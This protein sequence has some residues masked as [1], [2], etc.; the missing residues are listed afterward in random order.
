M[1]V[2]GSSINSWDSWF[3][4]NLRKITPVIIWTQLERKKQTAFV[5]DKYMHILNNVYLEYWLSGEH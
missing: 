5:G 1:T 2:P 3:I 4:F